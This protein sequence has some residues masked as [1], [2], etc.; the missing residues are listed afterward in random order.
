MD[1]LKIILKFETITQ[2]AEFIMNIKKQHCPNPPIYF[3]SLK[4]A[5]YSID[6]NGAV[7]ILT[8]VGILNLADCF[9]LTLLDNFVSFIIY[10]II[11]NKRVTIIFTTKDF[12]IIQNEYNVTV[13]SLDEVNDY[14]STE[15]SN[16]SKSYIKINNTSKVCSNCDKFTQNEYAYF[17]SN[18]D[19]VSLSNHCLNN[20][21]C[22]YK[23]EREM[24]E[25]I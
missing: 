24:L 13:D 1:D 17:C 22:D 3:C 8:S 7:E 12:K 23:F 14:G 5:N 6:E 15:I 25:L 20:L 4:N 2:S 11:D 18:S 21:N 19:F 10:H 9:R 16:K